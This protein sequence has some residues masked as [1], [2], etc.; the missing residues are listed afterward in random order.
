MVQGDGEIVVVQ[1]PE[2]LERE[3]G[4]EAGVDEDQGGAG[5]LDGVVDLVHRVLGGVAGPG[6]LALREQ[7]VDDR[8]R[9]GRAA[10]QGHLLVGVGGAAIAHPAADDVGIVHRRRQPDPAQVRRELLKA[11][12]IQRQQVAALGAVQGVDLVEDHAR[13]ALEIEPRALP[14]AEQRQLLGRGQQDVR[15]LHPLA[16]AA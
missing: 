3:L 14:G 15:R 9:A 4:L 10:D 2:L 11:R 5:L 13:Q 7:H 12:E 6:D 1:P 16:L 8:R